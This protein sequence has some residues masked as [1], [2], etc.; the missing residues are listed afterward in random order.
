MAGATKL[1]PPQV[2]HE[3]EDDVWPFDSIRPR[4]P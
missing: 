3:N 1:V 2:I 4:L